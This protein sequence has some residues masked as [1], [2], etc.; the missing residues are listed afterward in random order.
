MSDDATWPIGTVTFLLTDVERSTELWE[1]D[2]RSMLAAMARH[3]AIVSDALA[4]HGGVRPRDQGEGDSV[5]A[6]FDRALDGVA[7]A[8]GIQRDLQHEA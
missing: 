1:R 3:D 7:C 4:Q 6:V 5:M 2:R 8:V